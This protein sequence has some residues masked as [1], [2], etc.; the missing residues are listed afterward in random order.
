MSSI[1]GAE[2]LTAQFC[3]ILCAL[4]AP[5][6]G[7]LIGSYLADIS[8]GYKGKYQ[9]QA[10]LICCGFACL[11]TIAGVFSFFLSE[12]VSFTI[13]LFFL[14]LFGAAMFPTCFG[15]IISSVEKSK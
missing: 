4:T 11:A 6:P 3:F 7:S 13:G 10:L 8:G 12:V 2:P 14:L 5:I 9:T 15:I 1:L